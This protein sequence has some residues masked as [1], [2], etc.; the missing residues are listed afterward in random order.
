MPGSLTFNLNITDMSNII[1]VNTSLFNET[2]I[3]HNLSP[4]TFCTMCNKWGANQSYNINNKAPEFIF[5]NTI[6]D[7]DFRF[8]SYF[9]KYMKENRR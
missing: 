8:K 9:I 7:C 1:P 2:L 4:N 5:D 3:I 6:S